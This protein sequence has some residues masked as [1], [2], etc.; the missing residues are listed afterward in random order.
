MVKVIE[1][2]VL[3]IGGGGAA[4]RAA[5]E[6]DQ[7][8]AKVTVAVKG[9]FGLWG[10]R[11][12][13]ASGGGR[14]NTFGYASAPA[15]VKPEDERE[16]IFKRAM[17]CGL[18]M[19]DRHL[20]RILVEDVIESRGPL[21]KWGVLRRGMFL[22]GQVMWVSTPMPGLACVILGN[23]KIAIR[24]RTM[25]TDLLIRDGACVGAVG[26]DENNGEL[27]MLK[28]GSTIL[29]TGG[30]S[31][32]FMHNFHPSC[33]TGDGYVMG[34]EAGAEERRGIGRGRR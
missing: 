6:A 25:I 17:Q 11:G 24:D 18:G 4:A 13:G 28:A 32:L 23:S 21:E 3:V 14:A 1:T 33:I 22:I 34:Y 15:S 30:N 2:D 20:V 8:G 29:S 7:A 10:V 9:D 31:Q 26:I 5:L 19:A 12:S 16:T 27:L